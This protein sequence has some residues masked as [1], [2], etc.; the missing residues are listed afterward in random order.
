M[1]IIRLNKEAI[2]LIAAFNKE[3]KVI[4]AICSAAMLLISAKIIKN[5]SVSGYYAWRDDIENAGGKFVDKSCVIDKNLVTSPHYK[6]VG[7]WMAGLLNTYK[8]KK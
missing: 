3:N 8:N 5:R 1:E 6:Y 7:E 2:N 4:G